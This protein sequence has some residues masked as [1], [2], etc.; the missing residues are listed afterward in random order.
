[1]A[2]ESILI[3]RNY[4]YL[5]WALLLVA[6]SSL[7]F[8][9]HTPVGRPN[10]GTWLGYTL[11][12]VSAG[13]MVWLAWFGIRKRSYNST[14]GR[15]EDWLS[16]HVYL[17]LAL[18][19]VATLHSG[20]QLGWNIHTLLYALMMGVALS[21]AVG[22]YFYSRF[23]RLLSQNRHGLSADVMLSQIA[24]LDR[25]IRSLAMTLDDQTNRVVYDSIESTSVGIG[26]LSQ[27]SGT[28]PNCPTSAARH[29]VEQMGGQGLTTARRD[30]LARLVKK[31]DLLRRL[32][33][34]IRL[35]LGM[36]IWLY[37]HVPLTFATLAALIAH[38]VTIFYYW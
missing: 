8:L 17:G 36:R 37:V 33:R 13:L 29:Y 34:D 18:L 21:G 35:R 15:L 20:F 12:T 25:D 6:I 32:R 10:G 19:I 3:Y 9:I 2:H 4:R 7:L 31:E 11:G 30:L 16:A 27:I 14:S 38:V 1:M 22:L 28:E 26:F 24:D 5:R 23:P